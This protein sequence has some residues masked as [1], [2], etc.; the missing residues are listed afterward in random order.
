MV[1]IGNIKITVEWQAVYKNSNG[2]LFLKERNGY[3]KANW[4]EKSEIFTV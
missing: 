2:D 3:K 4:I 1:Y